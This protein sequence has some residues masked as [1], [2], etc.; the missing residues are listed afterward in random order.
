MT[1][2]VGEDGH[3]LVG[4]LAIDEGVEENDALGPGKTSEEGVGVGTARGAVH[5]I[6]LL[7]G[8]VELAGESVN[9]GLELAFIH[10]GKLVEQGQDED[11]IDG[12]EED[13]SKRSEAPNVKDKLAAGLLDDLEAACKDGGNEG[14]GDE[15]SLDLVHEEDLVGLLVESKLLLE[16]KG[17]VVSDG[18]VHDLLDHQE[19]NHEGDR[20]ADGSGEALWCPLEKQVASPGP[21]FRKS[22]VIQ[23]SKVL[24]LGNETA[25]DAELGLGAT[26]GL[27]LVECFLVDFLGENGGGFGGLQDTVLA[28]GQE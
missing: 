17:T 24:D 12:E 18:D 23:E 19:D 11:G 9:L 3:D 7:E 6:Q 21:Q 4:L 16:D 25:D 2:L 27:R 5:D 1:E 15:S 13:L 14:A 20:V 22:I 10:R 8:E 28:E 26:V